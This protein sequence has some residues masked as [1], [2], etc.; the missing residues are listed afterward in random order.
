[1]T[2][3]FS[4]RSGGPS[5][6]RSSK[7]GVTAP[8]EASPSE[9]ATEPAAPPAT[10][11]RKLVLTAASWSMMGYIAGQILRIAGN[12]VLTR[13]LAPDLFGIAAVATM[14]SVFVALLSDI[15]LHP[16]VIQNPR[17]EDQRFLD[18]AWVIQI[19]RGWVGWFA[20][21][22]I[23]LGIGS[24]A[25]HGWV[26]AQSVYATPDLPYI[27]I[28]ASFAFVIGGFQSTK[29]ISSYR[30]LGLSMIAKIDLTSQA[31]GLVV[32]IILS[33]LTQSVW[34]LVISNLI[35]S[36]ISVIL[37]HRWIAGTQNR[38]RI[39]KKDAFEI[40][41][42][43]RWIMVSSFFTIFSANGD[44][45][46][47]GN[48]ASSTTF[49]LYGLA[50]N[51]VSMID[52]VGARLYGSVGTPLLSK[53]ARENPAGLRRSY[54]K[55]R[56]PFDL[57]L[58]GSAGFL[59]ACGQTI[60]DLLYDHRYASA[61]PMLQTLSFALF[62]ARFN[63]MTPVYIAIGQPRYFGILNIARAVLLFTLVPL[64]YLI[65]GFN[66]ALWAIALHALPTVPLIYYFNS[67]HNLNS[68]IFEIFVLVAWPLG[69]KLG[70]M[71]ASDASSFL[72][73]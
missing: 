2:I 70:S 37:S 60:I 16:A 54:F 44:R 43:G 72:P 10:G 69:F 47:L 42:F 65:F 64:A 18:T 67:R 20:S 33:W 38:F 17:G 68:W 24:L 55:L 12:L 71:I 1:M 53:L 19:V 66:G 31:L 46:L 39:N 63:I 22:L 11:I 8:A 57:F 58:I 61:G 28:G 30:S 6:G 59:L 25:T 7:S 15:G 27:I 73:H 50:L 13:I 14:T 3:A 23:A 49:G 62:M 5:E 32:A 52:G 9:G 35:S 36:L 56:L 45:I 29:Y 26:P 41:T 51:L 4:T 48:W 34:A 21:I 40:L